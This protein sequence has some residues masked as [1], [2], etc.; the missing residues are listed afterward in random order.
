M[1]Y[2]IFVLIFAILFSLATIIWNY[3]QI[4]NDNLSGAMLVTASC[5]AAIAWPVALIILSVFLFSRFCIKKFSPLIERI[6]ARF[7]IIG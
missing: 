3:N 2:S 4:K 5:M 1:I 7:D 6:R